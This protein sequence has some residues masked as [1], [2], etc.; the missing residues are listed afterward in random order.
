MVSHDTAAGVIAFVALGAN[1]MAMALLLLFNPRSRAI[2][3]FTLFNLAQLLWLSLQG[4]LIL[5][6]LEP[7]W[8]QIYQIVVHM[9]PA[10][11]FAAMLVQRAP[12]RQWRPYL[13]IAAALA[14]LMIVD[15]PLLSRFSIV[16]HSVM[17][18]TPAFLYA[19]QPWR[20]HDSRSGRRLGA[21]LGG[22]VPLAVLGAILL[23]GGFVLFVLPLMTVLIQLLLFYGVVY[24]RYYDIEVRAARTGEL[25]A[26]AA[27]QDR[28]AL[29]GELAAT[30]AHEVRNPLT[31]IRSLTQMIAAAPVDDERR[32]RYT[33]VIL[34]EITRLDRIVG[35][36]TDLARRSAAGTAAASATA[37][38]PLFEDLCMLIEPRAQRAHVTLAADAADVTVHT[39]RDALAQALLNLLINAVAH[40]PP[41]GAVHLSAARARDAVTVTVRDQG[42]GVAAADRARIFEPFHSHGGTGLGLPVVRR[43]ADEHG[44]TVHVADAPGRGAEFC[45]AIPA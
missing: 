24:H 40:S 20:R 35:N 7:A 25:A 26:A 11:F 13:P 29:L 18:G 30:I 17:W 3:W 14:T 34:D 5:F 1:F 38:A 21:M 37:L 27:E 39:S 15:D 31:G 42:P 10:L 9:L 2:R 22:I 6:Q 33:G 28:L 12:E 23:E 36:L 45:I 44:W 19:R 32:G 41:H 4:L 16:W 8:W 43:L